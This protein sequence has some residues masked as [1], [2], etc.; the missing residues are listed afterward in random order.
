MISPYI[1]VET[2]VPDAIYKEMP[3]PQQ[4]H[5]GRKVIELVSREKSGL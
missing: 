3:N 5:R 2:G 1:P 4:D